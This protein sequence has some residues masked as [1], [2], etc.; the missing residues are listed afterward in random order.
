M[1]TVWC[2]TCE[3][4]GREI[5]GSDELDF[6]FKKAGWKYD[7]ET[8]EWTCDECA[9]MENAKKGGAQ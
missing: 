4:C 7:R 9:E 1:I 6:R 3:K 5:A 8:H 2:C